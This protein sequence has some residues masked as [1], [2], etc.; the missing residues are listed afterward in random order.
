VNELIAPLV[1]R[2]ILDLLEDIGGEQNDEVLAI[3]LNGLGHRVARRDVAECLVWLSAVRELVKLEE[4]GPY[5]VASI[6][7]DGRDVASGR[8]SIDGVSRHKTGV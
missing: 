2:A 1:R 5:F 3:L 7:P 8:L 4:L 6:L